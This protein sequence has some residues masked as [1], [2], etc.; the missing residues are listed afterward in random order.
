MSDPRF[1]FR[2]ATPTTEDLLQKFAAGKLFRIVSIAQISIHLCAYISSFI[3]LI[4]IEGG[5]YYNTGILLFIGITMLSMPCFLLT[6]WLI[7]HS[8]KIS[9]QKRIWGYLLNFAVLI[10]SILIVGTSYFA[11]SH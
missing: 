9:K 7:Q 5:G 11:I 10:W 1:S 4:M 2:A 8:L 3:K 6:R